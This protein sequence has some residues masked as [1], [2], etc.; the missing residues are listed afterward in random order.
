MNSGKGKEVE[1][2]SP[3]QQ[4]ILKVVAECFL[5]PG[6]PFETGARD[7]DLKGLFNR[8]AKGFDPITLFGFKFML[9]L[10]NYLPSLIIFQPR[11]LGG[12]SSLD[13]IRYLEK[14]ESSRLYSLRGLFTAVKAVVGMILYSDDQVEKQIKY[15]PACHPAPGLKTKESAIKEFQDISSDLKEEFDVCVIG[16]GAGGAV[17]AKEL[18]EAGLKTIMLEEGAYYATEDF[19]RKPIDSFPLY[20][21][22]NSMIFTLGSPIVPLSVGKGIGGATTINSCTC[23]RT[24]EE[25]LAEWERDYDLKGLS[26]KTLVPYYERV[27][28]IINVLPGDMTVIGR[29]ALVTKRGA[30]ALGLSHGPLLRNT[31]GCTGCGLCNFGC[32]EGSKQSMEKT[33]I[34]LALKAG[35]KVYAG[36]RVEKILEQDGK[37]AG[38]TGVVLDRETGKAKHSFTV[39]SKVVIVACG[40]VFSPVLL[41]KN[42]LG[43]QSGQ[44]GRHLRVHPCARVSALFDEEIE[45]WKGIM[46]SYYV[47]T[48]Q[49]EG[50]MIEATGLAPAVAAASLPF[51]GLKQKELMS[52]IKNIVNLG[53]LISDSSEGR[54]RVAPGGRPLITYYLNRE[55]FLKTLKGIRLGVDLMFAAGAK[56]VY[57]GL[58]PYPVMNSK[59]QIKLI[60]EKNIDKTDIEYMAFHPM[61]SCRMG[62]NPA[63]AVVNRNLESH[64]VKNLFISDASI[65][66]TSLGVN[67]Q[68]SIMAFATYLADYLKENRGKYFQ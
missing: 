13:R 54:V 11:T 36:C 6:G 25:V 60:T 67:P 66:P 65:F 68:L 40:A 53:L 1:Y 19:H 8:F 38:V 7:L 51:F 33:Y 49:K 9:S 10:L 45:Q 55:D 50:I 3:R 59:E 30:E 5:P 22:N 37:A 32:P 14:L 41:L 12:L 23:F 46:Q 2:L 29:N 43:N 42:R 16:S 63:Q 35:A 64:E 18:A 47:D 62:D 39:R 52:R 58:A 48:Y 17:A 44:V 27:E 24:P 26:L 31:R 21:R 56:E 4:E 57:P 28:K 61:G 15:Q 20:Y 34:P